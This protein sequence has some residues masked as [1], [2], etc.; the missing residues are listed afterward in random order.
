MNQIFTKILPFFISALALIV[1]FTGNLR[2]PIEY[3]LGWQ[4]KDGEYTATHHAIGKTN[5]F[6]F[7]MANHYWV[8]SNWGLDVIR[9]FLFTKTGFLGFTFTGAIV[10]V[11]TLFVIG[12]TFSFS[13]WELSFVAIIILYFNAAIIDTGFTGQSVSFLGFALLYFILKKFQDG[14]REAI[15]LLFPLF[16]FWTNLH[17]QFFLGLIILAVWSVVFT[18]S[19]AFVVEHGR[20]RRFDSNVRFLLPIT[21]GTLLI[22]I[23]N[24]FGINLYKD[25][26]QHTGTPMQKV[27]TEW[28][29]FE[30]FSI[31][32]I[33]LVIFGVLILVNIIILFFREK[34]LYHLPFIASALV[35]LYMSFFMR[36]YAWSMYWIGI[37]I[38]YQLISLL[39]PKNWLAF[40]IALVA[41][42]ITYYEVGFVQLPQFRIFSMSWDQYCSDS[43]ACSPKSAQ[44]L[45]YI[46]TANKIPPSQYMTTYDWGGFLIGNYPAILPTVDGRMPLWVDEN[47][48]SPF[49]KYYS[50]ERNTTDIEAS[51]YNLVYMSTHKPLYFRLTELSKAKRWRI[52]YLDD[53]AGIFERIKKV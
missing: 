52:L 24:P 44:V 43:V 41:L 6:S 39:K 34:F 9:Y 26:F 21:F 40:P 17:G 23:L 36:R 42:C 15:Y 10:A 50:Y 5:T 32:W 38:S 46:I 27:I 16:F 14:K 2:N 28:F 8:N 13:F 22:T 3:D 49:E 30:A 45:S 47:G 19:D 29:P 11:L 20:F 1:F 53:N 25:L 31:G 33:N 37:P 51:P 48:Y 4:L 7:E 12:R 35:L 18:V